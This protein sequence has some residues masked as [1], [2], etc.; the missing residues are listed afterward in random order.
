MRTAKKNCE[1]RRKCGADGGR[2]TKLLESSLDESKNV[3]AA[4]HR[5]SP[6]AAD[7]TAAK[8]MMRIEARAETAITIRTNVRR[9][10]A[11]PQNIWRSFRSLGRD[12]KSRKEPAGCAIPLAR[13]VR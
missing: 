13:I 8:P 2:A 9:R 3:T 1:Y 5:A 12:L 10:P 4:M 6:E 11:G 7:V